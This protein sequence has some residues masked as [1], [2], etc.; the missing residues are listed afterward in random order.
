MSVA[1]NISE[2][3]HEYSPQ[4]YS[5]GQTREF[6]K[7][8]GWFSIGLGLAEIAAPRTLSKAIGMRPH[9]VMLPLFGIR[10][11]AAGIGILI[12]PSRPEWIWARVAGDVLDLAALGNEMANHRR[13][14]NRLAI[15]M[16]A[17]GAMTA[18]DVKIGNDLS[19]ITS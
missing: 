10:E 19:H 12:R 6:A 7:A 5:P 3:V 2:A 4:E 16:A 14:R 18:L 8:L 11:I 17:V 9:P 1:K 13:T 15:T